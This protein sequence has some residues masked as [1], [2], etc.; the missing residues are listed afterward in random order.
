MGYFSTGMGDLMSSRPAMGVEISFC[1]QT[2]LNSSAL[3][4][5]LMAVQLAHVDRKIFWPCTRFSAD[6]EPLVSL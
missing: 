4:V 3:L 1:H 6:Y 5:S 2:F